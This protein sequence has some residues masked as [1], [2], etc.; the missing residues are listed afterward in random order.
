MSDLSRE[1]QTS[2]RIDHL[3]SDVKKLT[4]AVY[5]LS[6]V[7]GAMDTNGGQLIKKEVAIRNFYNKADD[8]LAN[9]PRSYD[10]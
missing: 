10:G 1:G 2:T 9:L 7:L 6:R 3:Q 5:E 4:Q 8:T